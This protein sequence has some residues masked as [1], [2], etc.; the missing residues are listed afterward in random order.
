MK[1]EREN[2]NKVEAEKG[3]VRQEN[4]GPILFSI[5]NFNWHILKYW[6]YDLLSPQEI[7]GSIS[8]V[9][10]C[11]FV[12]VCLCVCGDWFRHEQTFSPNYTFAE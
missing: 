8:G 7:L 9:R 12:F 5:V 2:L 11:L 1:T 4:G 3:S 6:C 10:L